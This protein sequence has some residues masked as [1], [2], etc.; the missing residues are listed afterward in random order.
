MLDKN[1]ISIIT[2]SC[3]NLFVFTFFHIL[4]TGNMFFFFCYTFTR[5]RD[6]K[7]INNHTCK[8]K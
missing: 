4:V 2:C 8:I 7:V 6:E 3:F 5:A 1:I